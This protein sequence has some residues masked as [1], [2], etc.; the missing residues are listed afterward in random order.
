MSLGKFVD[1]FND[2]DEF[3]DKELFPIRKIKISNYQ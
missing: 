2:T 1:Y 3:I